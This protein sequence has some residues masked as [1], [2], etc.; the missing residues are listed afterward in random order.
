MTE[1]WSIYSYLFGFLETIVNC[2]FVLVYRYKI[3]KHTDLVTFRR[4]HR[5][6]WEFKTSEPVAANYYP[7]NSR[8]YINVGFHV[9]T[10]QKKSMSFVND[11]VTLN[12]VDFKLFSSVM[13]QKACYF[14]NPLKFHNK[15][16]YY[17]FYEGRH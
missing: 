14:F 4:N 6:T 7:I 9:C 8:V 11:N 12:S 13:G 3:F 10:L 17:I 5:A 16:L 15:I 1:T 2:T